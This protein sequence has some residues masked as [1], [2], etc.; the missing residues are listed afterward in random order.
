MIGCALHRRVL[1]RR[2]GPAHLDLR[3]RRCGRRRGALRHHH[4]PVVV[5]GHQQILQA[6]VVDVGDREPARGEG[7]GGR[8]ACHQGVR[9]ECGQSPPRPTGPAGHARW[10]GTQR[11]ART[12]PPR[13]R[14]PSRQLPGHARHRHREPGYGRDRRS[15]AEACAHPTE[16]VTAVALLAI[17]P[18]PTRP[19][20]ER[21][22]TPVPYVKTALTHVRTLAA[23]VAVCSACPRR[24]WRG[25]PAQ[26]LT[27]RDRVRA[28]LGPH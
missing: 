22:A 20:G 25:G 9:R 4:E 24:R 16:I 2:S 11:S 17:P 8:L 10:R 15:L 19:P 14:A 5:V 27:D 28:R 7:T 13:P 26:P 3:R 1:Q 21:A 6:V 12:V 18:A 23:R